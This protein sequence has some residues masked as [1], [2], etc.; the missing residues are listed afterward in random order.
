[1]TQDQILAGQTATVAMQ[2]LAPAFEAVEGAYT[3]QLA[4]IAAAEPWATDKIKALAF[5]LKVSKEVRLHI[6]AIVAGG[7][8]AQANDTHTKK[9]AAMSPERRRILGL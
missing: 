3:R 4:T 6:E 1:M 5:G 2:H 7:D 9:I 8:I